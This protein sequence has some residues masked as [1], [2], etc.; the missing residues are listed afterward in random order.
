MLTFEI[1]RIFFK[2]QFLI[3]GILYEVVKSNIFRTIVWHLFC[4]SRNAVCYFFLFRFPHVIIFTSYSLSIG[5]E[6][7]NCNHERSHLNRNFY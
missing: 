3:S 1:G 5:M 6:I 2:S 4:I 7:I